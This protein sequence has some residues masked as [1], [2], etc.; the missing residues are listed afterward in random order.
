MKIQEPVRINL[1]DQRQVTTERNSA[2]SASFQ[3]I[4][5]SYSKELTQDHLHQLL[6]DIDKQGVQLSEKPTFN[7]LRK[8]K[9]LVKQF[10]GEVTKNGMGLYQTES[11]DPYGGNKKL[12]TVQ[13][14]DKKLME[15][16]DHVLNQQNGGLSILERIGEIKGLLINLYT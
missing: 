8:Y 16:T 12:K 15:L 9:N 2:N 10:M 14:L 5:N 6:Q 7:E 4:M 3:K 13:V 11:W 1:G